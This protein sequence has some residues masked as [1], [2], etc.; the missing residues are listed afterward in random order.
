[1]KRCDASL[2]NARSSSQPFPSIVSLGA[3]QDLAQQFPRV[4]RLEAE[5]LGDLDDAAPLEVAHLENLLVA[6]RQSFQRLTGRNL[7]GK[8]VEDP[9]GGGV[10]PFEGLLVVERLD[11]PS[12][13]PPVIAAGV[14]D[15]PQQPRVEVEHFVRSSQKAEKNFVRQRFG[16]AVG[17]AELP[18]GDGYEEVEVLR[19]QLFEELIEIGRASCRERV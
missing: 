11:Q 2:P 14:T 7:V 12:V 19:I 15:G 18:R 3:P 16:I 1:M 8:T 10:G 5:P 9:R 6:R 13:L 17:D 4:L